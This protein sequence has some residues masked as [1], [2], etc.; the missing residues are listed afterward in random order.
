MSRREQHDFSTKEYWDETYG[1]ADTLFDWLESYDDLREYVNSHF[2][3]DQHVLI[4][5][6][7]NST[8]SSAM[9]N[10]GYHQ[11]TNIDFSPV[12][13][14]QMAQRY[15][16]LTWSVMDIK[17]LSFP[18]DSFDAVL[19][20]GTLDALTCGGDVDECIFQAL[21]EYVRVL[22]PGGLAYVISFGQP[23][24][25]V[26]YFEPARDHSWIFDGFDQLPTEIAPHSHFHVYKIRKPETTYE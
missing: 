4:P 1:K 18:S 21:S 20:K 17:H 9:Y 3:R 15:P 16:S 5:G 22:R 2:T 19:D 14:E 26:E 6:C 10:D 25:R 7:G 23:P 11:L 13:I 12:V 8:L 24:D